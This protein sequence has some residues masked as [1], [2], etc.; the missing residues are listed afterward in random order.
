MDR[1]FKKH[2]DIWLVE[3]YKK[4]TGAALKQQRID[5]LAKAVSVMERQEVERMCEEQEKIAEQTAAEQWQRQ[6]LS[7]AARKRCLDAFYSNALRRYA[8]AMAT[9]RERIKTTIALAAEIRLFT[10]LP[11]HDVIPPIEPEPR[12]WKMT[13]PEMTDFVAIQHSPEMLAQQAN[14]KTR[15][16]RRALNAL[17]AFEDVGRRQ[18]KTSATSGRSSE[19]RRGSVQLPTSKGLLGKA[20]QRAGDRQRRDRL[21]ERGL[22]PLSDVQ[23][24]TAEDVLTVPPELTPREK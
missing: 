21:G 1:M 16:G 19:S 6:R 18:S 10:G 17:A 5:K 23:G 7:K 12:W 15:G 8:M 11:C 20:L 13:P 24:L 4:K 3:E 9:W 2:E 22:G 14:A